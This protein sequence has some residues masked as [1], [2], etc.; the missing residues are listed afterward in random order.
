M[1]KK[2]F[3]L[4]AF[5]LFFFSA[6]TLIFKPSLPMAKVMNIINKDTQYEML[7]SGS[8]VKVGTLGQFYDCIKNYKDVSAG[9]KF[10]RKEYRT[11]S[12]PFRL[13]LPEH[14]FRLD[15]SGTTTI[16]TLVNANIRDEDGWI[17]ST[18]TYSVKCPLKLLD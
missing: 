3:Y 1:I 11:E 2:V 17:T 7:V 15:F 9:S 18:E 10:V 12:M 4:F 14:I 6:F 16:T 8:L 13:V 5:G